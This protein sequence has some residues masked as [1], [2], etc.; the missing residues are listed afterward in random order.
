MRTIKTNRLIFFICAFAVLIIDQ[1]TK[2]AAS[3]FLT[4][5]LFVDFIPGVISFVKVF[6]TG[7]AFGIMQ[8]NTAIL[9]FMS[10]FACAVILFHVLRY[11]DKFSLPVIICWG[12]VT[13]GIVG[14]LVDR[15]FLGYV[16]D[17]IKPDFVNFPVFNIADISI[18]IG[19]FLII[20]LSLLKKP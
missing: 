14:N 6:N 19:V 9:I 15:I 7:A 20:L 8:D 11:H 3:E 4:Q 16:V 2:K 5:G 18:N 13:G 1:L 10:L 17:F 12:I